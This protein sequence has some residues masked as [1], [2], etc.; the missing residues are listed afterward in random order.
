MA[1]PSRT[2]RISIR[3]INTTHPASTTWTLT[4]TTSGGSDSETREGYIVVSCPTP[5][6]SFTGVP[7]SGLAPLDV[8]FTSTTIAPATGCDPTAWDWTFGDSAGGAG[9]IVAHTY[10]EDGLYDVCLTVTVPRHERADLRR[11]LHRRGRRL[12]VGE[13]LA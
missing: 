9:E 10:T 3:L 12:R 1:T 2:R 6:P 13:S 5:D 11:G 7:A 4:V 8:T